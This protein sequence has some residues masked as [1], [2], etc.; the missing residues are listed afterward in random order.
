LNAQVNGTVFY[1]ISGQVNVFWSP[2]SNLCVKSPTQ[3]LSGVPGASGNTGGTVGSCN[4]A[5]TFDMNAIIQGTGLLGTPM[6]QG[7]TV[8]IQAWQRDTASTKTTNLSD[9]LSFVVGP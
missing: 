5:Y 6:G 9:A 7:T 2:Q 4:G 3:R 1:G 8:V